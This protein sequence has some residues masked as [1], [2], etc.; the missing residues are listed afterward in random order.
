MT[1]NCTV[2]TSLLNIN[3]EQWDTY[4]RSW[5]T[6]L[7][8]FKN[9]LSL[10]S[11]MVIY[12][13]PETVDFVKTERQKIDPALQNTYIETIEINQLP[14]FYLIDKIRSIMQLDAFKAGLQEPN[15]PEYCR[16]EYSITILSKIDLVNQVIKKNPFNTEYFMW[17][18]GGICHQTFKT[19][20]LNAFFPKNQ[21]LT[22]IKDKIFLLCRSEPCDEDLNIQ[23]FYKSHVNRFG[24][25]VIIGKERPFKQFQTIF[26]NNL[27]YAL[28]NNL[29][30]S[31][32]SIYTICYLKHKD[33]FLLMRDND[34]YA[35][36]YHFL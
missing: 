14:K 6:Y 7:S 26:D 21:N 33:L 27:N 13:Q 30:D 28:Q 4:N 17:L 5:T 22:Q 23:H 19:E 20:H 25:G 35:L 8:Y 18:D 3:R 2:I 31:E 9:I 15:A 10:N 29:I 1:Q 32:Q 12:V 34:W 16:P 36:F 24:A 11:K